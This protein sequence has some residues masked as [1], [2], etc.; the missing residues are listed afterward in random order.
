ME[1]RQFVPKQNTS[2]VVDGLFARANLPVPPKMEQRWNEIDDLYQA[3]A[4]AIADTAVQAEAV[5]GK[6]VE[7][8]VTG[9]AELNMT[10][11][12]L[13]RDLESFTDRLLGIKA[14]H[15]DKAGVIANDEDF[16][17]SMK[18]FDLYVGLTEQFRAVTMNTLLSLTE[19]Y[20][21]LC[22]KLAK[23]E[24]NAA[25]ATTDA[26]VQG[27]GVLEEAPSAGINSEVSSK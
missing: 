12:G 11:V 10:V 22:Q 18:I 9:D 6:F 25:Q 24:E 26:P 21:D 20:D 16:T 17:L 23:D 14:L 15:K 19:K 3:M 2:S 4:Q 27:V 13:Q 5:I 7:A 1:K 8:G